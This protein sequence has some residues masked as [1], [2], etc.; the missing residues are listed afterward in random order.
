MQGLLNFCEAVFFLF[1]RDAA[2]IDTD[3]F[4]TIYFD[5]EISK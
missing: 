5:L 4:N 1:L 3:V 2:M